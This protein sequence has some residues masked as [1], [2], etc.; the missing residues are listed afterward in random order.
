QRQC[1]VLGRRRGALRHL[2]RQEPNDIGLLYEHRPEAREDDVELIDY[3]V[4]V[5]GFFFA[6]GIERRYQRPADFTGIIVLGFI[7]ET[8]PRTN[9]RPPAETEIGDG[10]AA[11]KVVR[12]F[13][14]LGVQL[15]HELLG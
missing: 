8:L 9:I 3:Q 15:L 13:L 12:Y 14:A 4:I 1:A 11:R 6:L 7:G 5:D 2:Q 10:F